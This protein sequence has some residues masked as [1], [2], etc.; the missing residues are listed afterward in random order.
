MLARSLGGI[1]IFF[2]IPLPLCFR[3]VYTY[4]IFFELDDDEEDFS[5]GSNL[6]TVDGSVLS[7]A[8]CCLVLPRGKKRTIDCFELYATKFICF[9]AYSFQGV[10]PFVNTRLLEIPD[11]AHHAPRQIIKI[12]TWLG[13]YKTNHF[14]ILDAS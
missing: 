6:T 12:S 3:N 8:N 11:I 2:L 10:E 9:Y 7:A 14:S 5:G 13:L 4:D 1:G